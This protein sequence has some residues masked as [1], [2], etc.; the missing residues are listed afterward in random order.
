MNPLIDLRIIKT[1]LA[2]VHAT[3]IPIN[4]GGSD[5]GSRIAPVEPTGQTH[6][7]KTSHGVPRSVS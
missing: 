5:V 7:R 3:T 6:N 2:I 1:F 4:M